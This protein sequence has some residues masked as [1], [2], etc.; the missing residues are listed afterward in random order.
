MSDGSAPRFFTPSTATTARPVVTVTDIDS[1]R[2]KKAVM[3]RIPST[4][5]ARDSRGKKY[6]AY[7]IESYRLGGQQERGETERRYNEFADLNKRLISRFGKQVPS[8]LTSR[9]KLFEDHF[10]AEF[11]EDRRLLL[12]DWIRRCVAAPAL[13]DSSEMVHFLQLTTETKVYGSV[14]SFG[15][16]ASLPA[17][18]LS[19]N[20]TDDLPSGA[21]H[22][23]PPAPGPAPTSAS[24]GGG[25]SSG[26]LG[27]FATRGAAP[28]ASSGYSAQQRTGSSYGTVGGAAGR[29]TV[30]ATVGGRKGPAV[31]APASRSVGCGGIGDDVL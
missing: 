10:A 2:D 7:A 6:T 23:A 12:E 17:P 26:G 30:G 4:R 21:S 18:A 15:T 19:A 28:S 8:F 25:G 16:P 11:V 3:I 31:A 29:G 24:L 27:R 5:L 14:S 13:R 22:T 20:T 1:L 9:N